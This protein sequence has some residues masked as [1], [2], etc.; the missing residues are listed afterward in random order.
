MSDSCGDGRAGQRVM[1]ATVVTEEVDGGG[2]GDGEGGRQA[3]RRGRQAVIVV[4]GYRLSEFD[5]H[6]YPSLR[7]LAQRRFGNWGR[8]TVVASKGQ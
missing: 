6:S 3:R 8:V 2:G 5:G 4:A 1:A 7:P